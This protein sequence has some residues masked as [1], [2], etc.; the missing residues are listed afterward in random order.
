[1]Y[2]KI[3]NT[4]KNTHRSLAEVCADLGVDINTIDTRKIPIEQCT[5]CDLWTTKLIL[6]YDNNPTCRYCADLVGL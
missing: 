2:K 1:M 6:D 4:L 3:A 5:H